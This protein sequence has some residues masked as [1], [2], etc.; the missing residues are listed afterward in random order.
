MSLL[1]Q[2]NS[3]PWQQIRLRTV[4]QRSL[5]AQVVI[6]GESRG[7]LEKGLLTLVGF[8]TDQADLMTEGISELLQIPDDTRQQ[9]LEP[10]FRR[11]WEKTSQLRIFSD[12]EGRMN[13]SLLQQS[14]SAGLYLVSQFTLFADLRKGNR[15]SFTGALAAP[16]AK[17]C[18]SDLL[19]FVREKC[20]DRPVLSGVFA[21]DM[22]VT[23]TNDGPVT[24]MFDCSIED[25]VE[26][27]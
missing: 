21:A 22:Q 18:F 13:E 20:A 11:W 2:S 23:L 27:L 7:V 8:A 25:G 6:D 9:L 10:L 5:N 15:P 4:V 3:N 19:L 26:G 14:A 12:S 17:H 1:S 16:L 24:L